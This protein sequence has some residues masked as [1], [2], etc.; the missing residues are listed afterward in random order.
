MHRFPKDATSAAGAP[1][2]KREAEIQI[3]F[4]LLGLSLRSSWGLNVVKS[5][6]LAFQPICQ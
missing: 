3:V 5:C 1:L 4:Q 2:A 6:A